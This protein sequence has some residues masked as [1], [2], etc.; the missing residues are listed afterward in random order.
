MKKI[1]V[2]P[3]S[4]DPITLGHQ[5]VIERSLDLFD[6]II[7]AIGVK[8]SKNSLF[9]LDKRIELIEEVFKNEKKVKVETFGGLTVDY[10]QEKGA[11]YILRGLRTSADFEFERSLAQSNKKLLHDIE[12][13]FFL[14]LPEHTFITSTIVRDIYKNSGNISSFVPKIVADNL[15]KSQ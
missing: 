10:C 13:V 14:T 1:A 9:S 5:S 7:I 15:L 6:E 8:S 11:K 3:G 4:F 2:F 12:T